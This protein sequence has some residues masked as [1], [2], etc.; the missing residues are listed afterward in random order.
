MHVVMR[1]LAMVVMALLMGQAWLLGQNLRWVYT[2]GGS[3]TGTS[4]KVTMQLDGAA[5]NRARPLVVS[6]TCP[7][8]ECTVTTIR[9]GTAATGSPASVLR[10]RTDAPASAALAVYVDSNSTGGTSLPAEPLTIGKSVLDMSDIELQ[11]GE[12]VSVLVTS[13]SSQAMTI[14]GKHEEYPK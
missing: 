11:P 13:G 5:A 14:N 10:T 1:W 7:A 3:K 6:V 4:F 9:G 12:V 2:W 8:A